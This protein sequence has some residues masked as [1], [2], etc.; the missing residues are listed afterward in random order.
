MRSGFNLIMDS[1]N[2]LN[3]LVALLCHDERRRADNNGY[4]HEG[5]LYLRPVSCP[6]CGALDPEYHR[7][8]ESAFEEGRWVVM[9]SHNDQPEAY[10]VLREEDFMLI[11]SCFEELGDAMVYV[12]EM[13]SLLVD[14]EDTVYL[15]TM[16]DDCV[17]YRIA[18]AEGAVMD[19]N[20]LLIEDED[21]AA[22]YAAD[23]LDDVEDIVD[24]EGIELE[25]YDGEYL[26]ECEEYYDEDDDE[27]DCDECVCG[28]NCGTYG[29]LC[30][31]CGDEDNNDEDDGEDDEGV[32]IE[33]VLEALEKINPSEEV[34]AKC[35]AAAA[36]MIVP[37]K[38]VILFNGDPIGK[39]AAKE[40]DTYVIPVVFETNE[41][42]G[43]HLLRCFDQEHV[44]VR[45]V[46]ESVL[47]AYGTNCGVNCTYIAER[48]NDEERAA[49]MI[50]IFGDSAKNYMTQL[51]VENA[52]DEIVNEEDNEDEE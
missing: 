46:S 31:G 43:E 3:N 41:E 17:V 29:C 40:R 51:L 7:V 10:H 14:E 24:P 38:W 47:L 48:V 9:V 34:I 13:L 1:E 6:E 36:E 16:D 35:K 18:T 42:A 50:E 28:E 8:A 19:L 2:N 44:K 30:C 22:M 11:P 26:C 12:K 37:G 20:I 5:R 45:E 4:V 52:L 25:D 33:E 49:E 39:R 32:E 23:Y 21:A 15:E 27:P